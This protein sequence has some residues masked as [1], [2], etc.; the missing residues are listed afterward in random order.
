MA[1][2]KLPGFRGAF[3]QNSRSHGNCCGPRV[4]QVGNLPADF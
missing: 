4:G 3:F 2:W 1:P